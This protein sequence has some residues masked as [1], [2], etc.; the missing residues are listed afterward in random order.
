MPTAAVRDVRRLYPSEWGVNYVDG[1]AYAVALNHLFLLDKTQQ[2]TDPT[3]IVTITPFE[4][5]VSSVEVAFPLDDAINITFDEHSRRLLL[6]NNRANEL[7]Q[8]GLDANQLLDP[9]SLVRTEITPWNVNK[10]AG[11]T[12]D[13]AGDY[14]Y[15]LDSGAQELLRIALAGGSDFKGATITRLDLA[16]LNHTVRGLAIHPTTGHLFVASPTEHLL[17]EL[18]TAGQFVQAHSLW[19]LGI[20]ASGGLAFAPS[21]DQ[22]DPPDV[23]HLLLT[24]SNLPLVMAAQAADLSPA[25]LNTFYLPLVQTK[26]VTGELYGADTSNDLA[27]QGLL[28]EVLELALCAPGCTQWAWTITRQVAHSEDDAEERIPTGDMS[29]L[30]SSDLELIREAKTNQWVGI[31]FQNVT[32]PKGATVTYAALIFET[33]ETGNTPTTLLIRGD[34]TDHAEPFSLAN[35]DISSRVSTGAR[36]SWQD[37]PAWDLVDENNQTPNLAPVV[38]EIINRDGWRNGNALAFLITGSGTR[39]AEAYDGEPTA[40]PRLLLEYTTWPAKVTAMVE[41]SPVPTVVTQPT[42]R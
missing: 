4:D 24:N 36:I 28:G 22:T 29:E 18:T 10:V 37:L 8:V 3:R 40:A 31:R 9:A 23:I 7:A 20:S 42:T 1:V 14:L 27:S 16:Y 21:A 26:E 13:P 11:L 33:D 25:M 17:Y 5:F 32:I 19:R 41:A 15:L 12:I 30:T 34:D 39:I 35:Y 6:F 2:A 38:Q